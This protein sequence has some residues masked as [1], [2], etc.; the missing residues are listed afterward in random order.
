MVLPAVVEVDSA[1]CVVVVADF[2]P[3]PATITTAR[4]ATATTAIPAA[5]G[6]Q[7]GTDEPGRRAG[8]GGREASLG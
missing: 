2:V 3:P 8:G 4:V 5:M 1:D 6:S 7:R